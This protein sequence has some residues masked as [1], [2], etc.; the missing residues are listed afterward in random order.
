MIFH[1]LSWWTFVSFITMINI[2]D[3]AYFEGMHKI[4]TSRKID[5]VSLT[6]E[7]NPNNLI[8]YFITPF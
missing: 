4:V 1:M 8:D 5:I 7:F 3:Q 6:I 2:P